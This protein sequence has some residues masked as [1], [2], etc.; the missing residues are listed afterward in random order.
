MKQQIKITM[1][2][3]EHLY[4]RLIAKGASV[5]EARAALEEAQQ[6][7]NTC[8]QFRIEAAGG[9]VVGNRSGLNA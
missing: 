1:S 3:R 8:G 7:I 6:Q 4:P 5:R 2:L 9:W